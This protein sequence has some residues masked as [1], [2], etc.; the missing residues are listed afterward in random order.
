[1]VRVILQGGGFF[2]PGLEGYRLRLFTSV[3]VLVLLVLNR[4]P[5]YTPEPTQV[6]TTTGHLAMLAPAQP[7]IHCSC[8]CRRYRL[9]LCVLV[10]AA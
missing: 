1:M 4:F 2:I 10:P 5:G 7:R 9:V 8:L 3:L 6:L